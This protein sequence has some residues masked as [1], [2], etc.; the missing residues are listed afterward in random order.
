MNGS[1]FEAN[2]YEMPIQYQKYFIIIIQNMRQSLYYHPWIRLSHFEFR[3][4]H[5]GDKC[6]ANFIKHDKLQVFFRIGDG[7]GL[8]ILHV[9][10]NCIRGINEA[11][12][13]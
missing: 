12:K 10:Q 5:Y 4:F 3:K 8:Y 6:V 2:W 13:E 1:L 7:I 9:V 11:I